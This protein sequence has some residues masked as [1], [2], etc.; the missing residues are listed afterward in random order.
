MNI[1]TSKNRNTIVI[2]HPKE[3]KM[4]LKYKMEIKEKIP[5]METVLNEKKLRKNFHLLLQIT[6]VGDKVRIEQKTGSFLN[7]S[8]S[9]LI[10]E[11]IAFSTEELIAGIISKI[12]QA[13]L[14]LV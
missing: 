9:I 6:V 12:R 13:E 2:F 7:K 3:S 11:T 8:R 10:E 1:G 14:I 4:A 5:E